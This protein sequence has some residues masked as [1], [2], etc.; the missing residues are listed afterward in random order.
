MNFRSDN[1]ASVAPEILAAMV[2]ANEGAASAYGEDEW[3]QRLDQEFGNL[4]EREVRVFPVS[5]GT[6]ANAVALASLTP[7]WGAILCHREAHIECDECGAPEFY[8]GGAKL[9]LLEGKCSKIDEAL[10][11]EGVARNERGVHSVKPRAVSVTQATERG[12]VYTPEELAALGAA[13]RR[14][15]LRF[16]MDGARFANAVAA[17]GC[18]PADISWRGGVD[19]LSFGATKNGAM[20]AEALVCFDPTLADEIGRRRKRA[21]HLI[22]KSRYI[23]A[24]LLAYLKDDL[25]IRLASRANEMAL[26][27]AAAAEGMLSCPVQTNQ[28]FITPGAEALGRLREQGAEFY[29]WGAPGS[30]EAR[31]VVSWNQPEAEVEAMAS[32]LR[33]L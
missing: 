21:G 4:F 2:A 25:W 15:D 30:G 19:L 26:V 12:C 10:V 23:A 28:V 11:L 18:R 22:S 9:V 31:L 3:S 5:T 16:H 6:A 1:T 27:L 32:L 8:S 20:A 13:A 33:S 7:P 24:Q 17:L 29:D 14:H